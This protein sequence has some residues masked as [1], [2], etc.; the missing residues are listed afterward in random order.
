MLPCCAG[1]SKD[2]ATTLD[3]GGGFYWIFPLY[4]ELGEYLTP[5][6]GCLAIV[7]HQFATN[8]SYGVSF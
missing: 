8:Y 6:A 2:S 4:C 1:H 7:S 3:E 5:R